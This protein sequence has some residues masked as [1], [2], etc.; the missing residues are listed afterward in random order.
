MILKDII[1]EVNGL[2]DHNPNVSTHETHVV[3]LVNRH[4]EELCSAHPWRFLQERAEQQLYAD[5][6]GAAGT[7]LT[8]ANN[9]KLVT[10]AA[11]AWLHTGMEGAV[12]EDTTN[13]VEYRIDSV[14]NTTTA[15][16]AEA[17]G[18]SGALS[19]TTAFKVKWDKIKLPRDMVDFLGITIR[20]EIFGQAANARDR[21]L[22]YVD[23]RTEEDLLLEHTSS[24]DTIIITDDDA[25]RTL[26]NDLTI[27]ATVTV[28]GS[29]TYSTK[30]EYCAT[31]ER[32]GIES[33]PSPVV[34]GT[35]AASG[36]ERTITIA[37]LPAVSGTDVYR[38]RI[39][40]RN[41]TANTG[42]YQV[43]E[44]VPATSPSTFF[45]DDGSFPLDY[46]RPLYYEGPRDTM[47]LYKRPDADIKCEIRYMRRPSRLVGYNDEPQIPPQYH[48]IL[49]YK[50]VADLYLQYGQGS[51][52]NIYEVKAQQRIEQMKKR[53]LDRT[54]RLYRKGQFQEM[55]SGYAYLYGDPV[56][57]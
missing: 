45:D 36:S 43:Y 14:A 1:E 9:S 18:A 8:L 12:I 32:E 11:G 39:Y 15:Y 20:D 17:T 27:T 10:A 21:R 52:S 33:A 16:L 4:Y 41:A 49:V 29:L 28:G 53:Y 42:W 56:K 34:S 55:P 47:R 30:Y 6:D 40:R 22:V 51:I 44:I 57:T 25:D 2:L 5:I 35:I 31:I 48:V 37:G 38:K 7:T 24:G 26:N 54:D 46:D 50:T 23:S 13:S 3:R 19:A